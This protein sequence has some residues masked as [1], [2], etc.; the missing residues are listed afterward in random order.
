MATWLDQNAVLLTA[1]TVASVVVFVGSLF[2]API[3][4]ARIPADYFTH[5][6]RPPGRWASRHPAVRAV[7]WAIKNTFGVALMAAGLAMLFTPGQGLL[8][9]L[10]G[11]MLINFPGK[12]RLEKWL[13][14]RRRVLRLIN[15]IRRRKGMPP[16]M[17]SG[18]GPCAD[19]A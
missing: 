4:V 6:R 2:A 11:F 5:D 19:A 1:L 9:L 16:M 3:I 10:V 7:V 18:A 17:A 14:S 13:I 12:Y 15:W 8:T